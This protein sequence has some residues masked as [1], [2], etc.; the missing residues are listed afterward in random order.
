MCIRMFQRCNLLR[1][2]SLTGWQS[3]DAVRMSAVNRVR[4]TVSGHQHADL[5]IEA[6]VKGNRW[7]YSGG[8][9][10]VSIE[11]NQVDKITHGST[12]TSTLSPSISTDT[13]QSPNRPPADPLNE[14]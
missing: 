2:P 14:R 5:A 7:G 11:E 9:G 1:A 6:R 3:S 13:F 10:F 4:N 8:I 12:T